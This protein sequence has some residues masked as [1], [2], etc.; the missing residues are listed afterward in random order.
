MRWQFLIVSKKAM[1]Y[2]KCGR[3][4]FWSYFPIA[5]CK[6]WLLNILDFFKAKKLLKQIHQYRR[7]LQNP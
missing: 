4:N 6:W 1:N 3:W 5:L 2:P 7:F